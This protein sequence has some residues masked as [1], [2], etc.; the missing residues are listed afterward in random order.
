MVLLKGCYCL[1]M[2]P[3][4]QQP[5]DFAF[6][7]VCGDFAFDF[8]FGFVDASAACSSGKLDQGC[9]HLFMPP[10]IASCLGLTDGKRWRAMRRS[11]HIASA[12]TPHTL[13]VSLRMRYADTTTL[14]FP[15]STIFILFFLGTCFAVKAML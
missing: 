7:F 6:D 14:C 9:L 5:Q 3:V 4:F 10:L 12:L 15:N 11:I 13:P 8:V 1:I 2:P